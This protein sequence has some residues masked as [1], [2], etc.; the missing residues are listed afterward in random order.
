M[1]G[2]DKESDTY[3]KILSTL[4]SMLKPINNVGYIKIL[5]LWIDLH[6]YKHKTTNWD[7]MYE[8]CMR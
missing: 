3:H 5:M 1:D 4:F 6:K 8:I 7:I 2:C